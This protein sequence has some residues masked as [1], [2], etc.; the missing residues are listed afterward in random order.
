MAELSQCDFML[1]RYVPNAIRGESVNLGL[2]L[3]DH[4]TNGYE[5]R[6]TRDSRSLRRLDPDADVELL[7]AVE[8]EVRERLNDGGD[9]RKRI[10]HLLQDS[11]SNAVQVS[12]PKAVLTEAPAREMDRLEE[13]YLKRIRRTARG[14]R[15]RRRTI[16]DKMR[17]AFLQ[18]GAWDLMRNKISVAEYTHKGDPLK[19]D[20]GY[21][22]NGVVKFFH[23]VSLPANVNTAKLLAFT[24]PQIREGAARLIQA[25]T[26]FTAIVEPNL[27]RDEDGLIEFALDTL[28]RNSIKVATTDDLPGLAELARKE[29]RV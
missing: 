25:K 2:V 20:C 26:E 11:F 3:F 7:E 21:R 1:V 22:P 12:A 17:D 23:A 4:E 6:F 15:F 16:I 24:Y 18:A 14:A 10:L 5:V 28:A 29:L 8:R 9:D 13:M 27:P 19:I